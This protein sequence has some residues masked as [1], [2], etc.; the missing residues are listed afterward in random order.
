MLIGPDVIESRRVVYSHHVGNVNYEP[1]LGLHKCVPILFN[2]DTAY[3]T[4]TIK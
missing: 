2:E 4:E 1:A 3:H